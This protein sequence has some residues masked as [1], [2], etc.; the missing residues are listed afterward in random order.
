MFAGTR[1]GLEACPS[2][3]R[4]RYLV[5]LL[6]QKLLGPAN[7]DFLRNKNFQVVREGD[8][9]DGEILGATLTE[10]GVTK[11]LRL[12]KTNGKVTGGDIS[13]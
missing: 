11:T 6:K 10:N 9:P 8:R 2:R 5:W 13:A 12:Q 1:I 4:V 7:H 3:F